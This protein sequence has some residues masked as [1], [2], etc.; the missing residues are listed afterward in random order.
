MYGEREV[1]DLLPLAS[2]LAADDAATV[3]RAKRRLS[4]RGD[5]QSDPCKWNHAH[6]FSPLLR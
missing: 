6:A 2:L 5:A 3:G 4:R 1:A